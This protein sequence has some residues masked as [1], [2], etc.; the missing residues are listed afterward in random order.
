MHVSLQRVLPAPVEKT[1]ELVADI[2]RR[3]EWVGIAQSRTRIGEGPPVT[4]AEYRA[5]DKMPGRTV[6]YT[7]RIDRHEPHSVFSES[8][9]GP[10]AGTSTMHFADENG[11]T[12]LQV[13][14]DLT[15]PRP[16]SALP[17]VARA[18]GSFAIGRD[19]KRLEA[20]LRSG[21]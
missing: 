18:L 16:F 5:I 1:Y 10:M 19:L 17:A 11:S 15:I 8:W 13:E 21:G 6:E 20:L 9:D 12:R 7:Q 2:T 14:A 4:G 3:P